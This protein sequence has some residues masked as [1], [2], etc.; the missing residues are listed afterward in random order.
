M[1]FTIVTLF[2]GMFEGPLRESLLGK[3]IRAGRIEVDCVDPRDFAGGRHRVVDDTPFGGGEGMVMKPEPLVAAIEHVR[4]SRG[5]DQVLMLSPRGRPFTQGLARELA[6]F[7]SLALVCG[8][9]EGIDERVRDFVDGELS[10]GDY[11]LSGGEPA[12]WIV[13]DAVTRLVPGV[14]GNLQ[15]TVE[16]S[17]ETGLLEYPQYTRPR[18]F[19][20]RSVP[21][22][23]LSGD[24][25]R[26]AQWRRRQS[27]KKTQ[28]TRPDL[29]EGLTLSEEDRRL[30]EEPDPTGSGGGS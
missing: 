8:R 25:G 11:V 19:R 21:E 16:E 15:S 7:S 13:V 22:V 10:I 14:L 6:G 3:A 26:I 9:Y 30:L 23:L 20:G 5:P 12:A 17:F 1:R 27:L 18:E 4:E 24:H 28:Q 2:P 29:L